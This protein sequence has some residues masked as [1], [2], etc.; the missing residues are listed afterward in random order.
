VRAW[1]WLAIAVMTALAAM[2]FVLTFG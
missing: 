1:N 2:Y